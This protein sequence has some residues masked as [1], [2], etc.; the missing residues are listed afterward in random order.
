MSCLH[1]VTFCSVLNIADEPK[2]NY[3]RR[4]DTAGPAT[5]NILLWINEE[6]IAVNFETPGTA[7]IPICVYSIFLGR[8]VAYKRRWINLYNKEPYSVRCSPSTGV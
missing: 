5:S 3:N 6:F 2:V 1:G 4:C 8:N 7:N